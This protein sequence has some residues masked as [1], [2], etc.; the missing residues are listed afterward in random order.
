MK[1]KV[2]VGLNYTVNGELVR[3]EPGE[4]VSDIPSGSVGWLKD[5]G[6]IEPVV[7]R[8]HHAHPPAVPTEE[9]ASEPGE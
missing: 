4:V 7:V 1:Y 8:S 2:N 3:A 5:Q 9:S 6:L